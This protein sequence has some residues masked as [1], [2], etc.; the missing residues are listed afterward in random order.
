MFRLASCRLGCCVCCDMLALHVGVSIDTAE[1][2]YLRQQLRDVT[3]E[4]DLAREAKLSLESKH[5]TL[6][7]D[8]QLLAK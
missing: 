8:H 6:T 2:S 1:L 5:R 4:L 3:V 7:G